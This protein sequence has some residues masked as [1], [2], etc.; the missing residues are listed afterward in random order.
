MDFVAAFALFLIMGLF[1]SPFIG[2]CFMLLLVFT[3]LGGLLIFFSI[4][5]IWFLLAGLFIYVI[6]LVLKYVKW[7]KLPN[8]TEYLANHPECKLN[9]GIACCKCHSE[10]LSN[11]GLFHQRGKW[12]FYTCSQCGSVLFRFTVL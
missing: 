6:G 3:L 1:F 12:R 9:V 2:G 11:Q 10:N 5:F 8:I 4:N 7:L